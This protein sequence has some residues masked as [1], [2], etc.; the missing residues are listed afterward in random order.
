MPKGRRYAKKGK[1]RR[2]YQRRRV[3]RRAL[4]P[5]HHF[6]EMYRLEDIT[7]A[8]GLTTAGVLST[9]IDSLVNWPSFGNL[10]DLYKITGVKFKF[11]Y[12]YNSADP[13]I[14]GAGL[15]TLYTAV[16][17]DPMVPAPA[18]VGDILNDDSIKIHRCDGLIGKG[19]IYIKSPKPDM[20]LT[21]QS[22][23]G[24]PV[25][26]TA[27]QQWNYGVG[28]SKQ[29]WLC[30]GGNAQSLDQSGVKHYGL[31]YLLDNTLNATSQVVEVY[32]TLYFTMK[33]QD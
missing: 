19:G 3:I 10:Y 18:N 6:K 15:P 20:T 4:R 23:T 5:V 2:R 16:N 30:T 27:V 11:L 26:G 12:K 13:N 21:V 32:A 31:R 24:G 22:E 25:I 29:P 14:G 1:G 28:S 33:E 8:G 9:K 17:R 7:V